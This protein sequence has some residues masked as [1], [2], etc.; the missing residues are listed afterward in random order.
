[1]TGRN[2]AAENAIPLARWRNSALNLAIE[3]LRSRVFSPSLISMPSHPSPLVRLLPTRK[4]PASAASR[5]KSSIAPTNG[6]GPIMR[7]RNCVPAESISRLY[8]IASLVVPRWRLIPLRVRNSCA[9]LTR[10][11]VP[12]GDSAKKPGNASK[13]ARQGW[14]AVSRHLRSDAR[15]LRSSFAESAKSANGISESRTPCVSAI[16]TL[17]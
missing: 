1:M 16:P 15:G 17:A 11:Y 10:W 13:G 6:V 2:M 9:H 8:R 5:A 14:V 7:V 12:F 3:T 4:R